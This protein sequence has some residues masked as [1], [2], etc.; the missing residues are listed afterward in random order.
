MKAIESNKKFWIVWSRNNELF[1]KQTY[2]KLH[3]AKK[4]AERL[5]R[6]FPNDK[7]YVAKCSTP[8][9]YKEIEPMEAYEEMCIKYSDLLDC[10][11]KNVPFHL[12]HATAKK[13]LI[14]ANTPSTVAAANDL[15]STYSQ[16]I[17]E[18]LPGKE[19]RD[20]IRARGEALQEIAKGVYGPRQI[21]MTRE[22]MMKVAQKAI[23]TD[24]KPKKVETGQRKAFALVNYIDI[25]HMINNPPVIAFISESGK[26]LG[27]ARSTVV[28]DERITFSVDIPIDHDGVVKF[29]NIGDEYYVDAADK[30]FPGPNEMAM[31]T[32]TCR[33]GET[34]KDVKITFSQL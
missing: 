12:H 2:N 25:H 23:D 27:K 9:D 4:E 22:H 19:D 10:V 8:V 1:T 21:N 14:R 5:L 30:L 3:K 6:F 28:M 18:N 34:K 7:F 32:K 24:D 20:E 33:A 16:Q 26:I 29:V 11:D 13:Q 17:K 15:I 31:A